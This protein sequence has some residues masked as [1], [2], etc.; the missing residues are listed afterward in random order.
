MSP[1]PHQTFVGGAS[2][3]IKK[4]TY[5]DRSFNKAAP[6][7]WNKRSCTY[8]ASLANLVNLSESRRVI[9]SILHMCRDAMICHAIHVYIH[10]FVA[11]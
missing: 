11:A 3:N 8:E 6:L 1:T 10:F 7:F 9:C 4:K 5:G 2:H